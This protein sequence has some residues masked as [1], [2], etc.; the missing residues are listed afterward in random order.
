MVD[1][2]NALQ[3]TVHENLLV[4]LLNSNSEAINTI[5]RE[6]HPSSQTKNLHV[7]L[8]ACEGQH[9]QKS[10]VFFRTTGGY[11]FGANVKS[12]GAGGGFNQVTRMPIDTFIDKF[13]LDHS[14]GEILIRLTIEK[15]RNSKTRKWITDEYG[16]LIQDIIKTKASE[17]LRESLQ[18]ED[19]P[20]LLVLIS[21]AKRIARIYR[22]DRV[23]EISDQEMNVQITPRG[24]IQLNEAFTIQRKGGNGKHDKHAKD[25]IRHGG[26]NIQVKMKCETL[27]NLLKSPIVQIAY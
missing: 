25:D 11:N 20:E 7:I 19:K 23:L 4:D 6:F 21:K 15:S 5:V 14:I 10:D 3:G 8:V 22:M 26:N 17:V 24:V 18:G 2:K 13:Q 12:Y 16:G 1:N 9:Q 27:A